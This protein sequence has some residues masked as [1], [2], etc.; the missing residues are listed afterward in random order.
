MAQ[1]VAQAPTPILQ[2]FSNA[3]LMNV[4]G[5][6][7]TQVGSVNYPTWQDAAGTTPLPNPIPL[8]SRGEISNTSGVSSELYLA[9][10]VTYTLTLK[11]ASGNQIWV[12]NNVTAQG[13]SATGQMTDEGPFLAGPNFTGSITTNQL[14]V[15]AF[16]SGAPLAVGQTLFGAGITAGTT[17]TALGTGTGGAGTYTV[18]TPQ[19]V[20]SEPM[21]AAGALQF[22]PGFSTSLTLVGF[23]GAKSNLWVEFDAGSQGPDQYSLSGFVLTF[24]APIPVGTLEVN[25]KGGTTATVGTPGAGTVT[26]VSVA[27]GANI[28]SSKL[29]FKSS[30]AGS[31]Q[32]TV[33]SKLSDIVSV[34]DFPGVDPTGVADSTTGMQ[35]AHNTGRL[36]YYPAGLYKFST[37]SFAAGGIIGDSIG[38]S[39]LTSID[40]TAANLI[41]YTGQLF[42]TGTPLFRD[43]L[44]QCSTPTQKS[45]GAGIYFNPPA[46]SEVQYAVLDNTMVFNVPTGIWFGAASKFA[47]SK[48]RCYNYS[49]VG[50]LV[51]NTNVADSGDSFISDTFLSTT[52]STGTAIQQNASGGLKIT[53]TKLL[54]GANGYVLS[55]TGNMTTGDLLIDNTSIENMTGFAVFL[56]RTS[57]ANTFGAIVLNNLQIANCGG[58]GAGGSGGIGTDSSG[59]FS[60]IAITG[61]NIVVAPGTGSCIEL[62]HVDTFTIDGGNCIGS[63][64]SQFGILI[65]A[66]CNIGTIGAV[67]YRNLANPLSNAC[68][69]VSIQKRV[70][71]AKVNVTCSTGFGGNFTG[72]TPVNFP[73][74]LFLSTPL[75][76]ASPSGGTN[77]FAASAQ[78]ATTAGC[79]ISAVATG[80]G[81][82]VEVTYRAEADF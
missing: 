18:S 66:T 47:I 72:N 54:G 43:F 68:P 6:L 75:V 64:G 40:A 33:L 34:L 62:S 20:I 53:N 29:A 28:N 45:A 71:Q 56:G 41:T 11:D 32:R 80:S 21:G 30:V 46:S 50:I 27:A 77:P 81:N 67:T 23:Y 60:Q 48:F 65:D 52:I 58:A 9:Q 44:L 38:Q 49:A 63:T 22:A 82:V 17:I 76:V 39:I 74:G 36:I 13:T 59:A 61:F 16:A 10:G 4:G 7:L 42:S 79:T 51:D 35:A 55:F 5:S 19:T 70:I 69:N 25:V 31:G 3:G 73:S 12:A 78:G 1:S 8:N 24:N 2:F 26:D 14:T 57:G 37:I 15:S